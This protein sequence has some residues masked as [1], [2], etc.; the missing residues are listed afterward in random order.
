M[1]QF[2]IL[3]FKIH[4]RFYH[5]MDIIKVT[6]GFKVI[7]NGWIFKMTFILKLFDD[8]LK[9]SKSNNKLVF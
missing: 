3:A 7:A 4:E 8:S 1:L 6:K 5:E 9:I 2:Q